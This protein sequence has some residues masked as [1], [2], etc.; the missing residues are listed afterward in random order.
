MGRQSRLLSP[1]VASRRVN[2]LIVGVRCFGEPDIEI[3]D[4][5]GVNLDLCH[6]AEHSNPTNSPIT[7][8]K[9]QGEEA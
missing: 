4:H 3:A 6:R 2:L 9:D 8:D 5:I 1:R 7:T